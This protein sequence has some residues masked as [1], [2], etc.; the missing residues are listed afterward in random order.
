MEDEKQKIFLE[1]KSILSAYVPPLVVT[2]NEDKN[3]EISGN[4]KIKIRKREVDSIFFASAVIQ[5]NYVSF[6]FFPIYTHRAKFSDIPDNLMKLLKG[7]SC[8]HIKKFEDSTFEE[9]KAILD[10]GLEIYKKEG[11]V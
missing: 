1:L 10:K 8:F 5:K 4:K 6:Y 2:K 11:W 9:I 7:K 3:Y